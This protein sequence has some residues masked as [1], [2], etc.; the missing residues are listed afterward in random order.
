M[1]KTVIVTKKN[2]LLLLFCC[3]VF[4]K[5]QLGTGYSVARPTAMDGEN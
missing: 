3:I 4:V 1:R 5:K 2:I